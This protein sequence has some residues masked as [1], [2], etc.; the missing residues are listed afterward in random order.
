MVMGLTVALAVIVIFANLAADV[1]AAT[2]DRRL[3]E[4]QG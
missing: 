1:I 2:L 3:L 4:R